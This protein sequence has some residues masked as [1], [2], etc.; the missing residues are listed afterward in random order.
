MSKGNFDTPRGSMLSR[1]YG[2]KGLF[3]NRYNEKP[4]SYMPP[5]QGYL[6]PYYPRSQQNENIPRE[7]SAKPQMLDYH[8]PYQNEQMYVKKYGIL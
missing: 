5:V 1:D 2:S 6:P 8:L 7:Y 4:Q 3:R